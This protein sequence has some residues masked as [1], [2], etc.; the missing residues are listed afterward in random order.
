MKKTVMIALAVGAIALGASAAYAAVAP[1]QNQQS[2]QADP[3]GLELP[4]RQQREPRAEG[5]S[6]EQSGR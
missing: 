3:K 1:G 4:A 2:Q 6:R 5:Q